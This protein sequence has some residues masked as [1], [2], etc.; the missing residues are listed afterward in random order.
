MKIVTWNCNGALRNK[1]EALDELR[2]DVY[3][4]QECENPAL[5]TSTFQNW[6]GNYLWIGNSKHKGLG[7]F[8]K[9]GNH[10]RAAD[11]FGT[12]SQ[13]GVVNSNQASQWSTTDLKLFAPFILNEKYQVLGLWTKAENADAFRYIGQLWKYLQI[14]RDQLRNGNTI[15]L[16]DFNSNR[17]WDKPDRW[18]NHSDVVEELADIGLQSVYHHQKSERQGEETTPTFFLQR[19]L[20][21]S[22]HID[23]V[24]V[25]NDLLQHCK[26][27]IGDSRQW[28]SV[29]DHMPMSLDINAAA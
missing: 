18:W 2:A 22:Y 27:Q 16:G 15:V 28:L 9:N 24:F 17:I 12:F 10:V 4:V 29:S 1:T 25:S 20:N 5:S 26:V 7:I 21:K 6:A 11:W 8:P 3:V 23:Y 13:P 19:N 14:H